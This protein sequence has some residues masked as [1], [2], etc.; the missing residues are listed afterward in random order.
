MIK[1]TCYLLSILLSISPALYAQ[2]TVQQ[3]T[4]P[5][6]AG[7]GMVNYVYTKRGDLPIHVS[8]WGSVRAPGRYE[9]PDGTSLGDFLSLAGGPGFDT[10]G[11]AIGDQSSSR[12]MRGKTH[13]RLSRETPQ[14]VRIILESRID[15][16]LQENIRS[17]KIQDGDILMVDMV[18]TFNLMDLILL[19]S[20]SASVILLLDRIFSIF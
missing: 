3:G 9:I 5:G 16:L 20:S 13:I 6:L 18:R 10:R 15:N 12:Q 7:M 2:S 14:G 8:I 19:I 4:T 1:S 11:F 17:F